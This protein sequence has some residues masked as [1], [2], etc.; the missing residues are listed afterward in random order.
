[1]LQKVALLETLFIRPRRTRVTEFL[2]KFTSILGGSKI[3]MTGFCFSW[4]GVPRQFISKDTEIFVLSDGNLRTALNLNLTMW[5]KYP[6][7][8]K[9]LI[10]NKLFVKQIKPTFWII[11]DRTCFGAENGV[12]FDLKP[13]SFIQFYYNFTTKQETASTIFHRH[14]LGFLNY[15]FERLRQTTSGS[16]HFTR[17][18]SCSL[19][20]VLSES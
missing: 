7:S 1:M 16:V 4:W 10:M 9:S 14:R 8:E 18:K 17:C 12:K 5:L 20:I 19:A 6:K 15:S 13:L 2:S 11:Y 3:F